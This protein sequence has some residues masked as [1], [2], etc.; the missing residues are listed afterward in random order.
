VDSLQRPQRDLIEGHSLT[1]FLG[2]RPNLPL[3][4]PQTIDPDFGRGLRLYGTQSWQLR[5]VAPHRLPVVA[6]YSGRLSFHQHVAEF[7]KYARERLMGEAKR[8]TL[9][10]TASKPCV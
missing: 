5:Y 3:L 6:G 10:T 1:G 9:I 7:Q 2:D 4:V 8:T